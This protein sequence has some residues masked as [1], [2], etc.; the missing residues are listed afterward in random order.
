MP[1]TPLGK[2]PYPSGSQAPA[3]AADMMAAFMDIDAR[4]VLQAVDAADRDS[5]YATAPSGTLVASGPS[6][7]IWMKIGAGPADW[8]DIHTD[9]GWIEKGFTL[10]DG[11]DVRNKL[12]ARRWTDLIEIRGDLVR[13]GPDIQAL[14]HGDISD[15][16]IVSV[17]AEFRPLLGSYCVGNFR[18]SRTS[19]GTTLNGQGDVVITDMHPSTRIATGDFLLFSYFFLRD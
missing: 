17:P 16:R 11:W 6:K 9:T 3:A 10:G 18:S 13:T 2:I 1:E 5:R 15:T 12:R 14:D 4:L 7:S 19:G 8:K